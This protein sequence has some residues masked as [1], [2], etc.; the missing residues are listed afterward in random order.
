MSFLGSVKDKALNAAL[1]SLV[2]D[3]ANKAIADYGTLRRLQFEGGVLKGKVVLHG[4]EERE[5]DIS[6]ATVEISPNGTSIR[7]ANFRSNLA[8]AEKALNN[9]AARSYT[10]TSPPL[11]KAL[12][13][14]RAM[15]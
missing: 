3:A 10:V 6:C 1:D 5:I 4:L 7:L 2:R 12:Q 9:F 13:A 8:F 15:L 14:I 11:Q